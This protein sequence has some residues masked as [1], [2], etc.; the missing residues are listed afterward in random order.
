MTN[1]A[2]AL[3]DLDLDPADFSGGVALWGALPAIY[4]T[5]Q[6]PP[7]HGVHV[8][9][10]KRPNQNKD[11]DA[12]Y[13]R[14]RLTTPSG[15]TTIS[16]TDAMPYVAGAVFSLPL[17]SISCPYC[18]ASHLDEGRFSVHPHQRHLCLRCNREFLEADRAI[19][20]P[21]VDAKR[22]LHDPTVS[23]TTTPAKRKLRL[24]Q[25]DAKFS[26]GLQIWGS[27]PAVLW[28]AG[29]T[30][31][32]GIHVHAFHVGIDMPIVDNTFESVEIDS[33]ILEACMVRV[34]MIQQS[35]MHL[36]GTVQHLRCP[37]CNA[38]HFDDDAPFAVEP[39]CN[40]MCTSCLQTFWT[41]M[42]V[43]SNPVVDVLLELYANAAIVGRSKNPLA[44]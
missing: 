43:V 13:G 7:E 31:E 1:I 2:P 24:K 33:L 25:S 38:S 12:S 9:A 19:G 39:H 20:N 18:S 26:G 5:T 44:P 3:P 4:D 16:E 11:I 22:K 32:S 42:P 40:H 36:R 28:T 14:V 30:E 10:R 34:F 15:V 37:R 29:R 35:L 6:Y 41:P 23:R 8:H 27:N 17:R 21:I